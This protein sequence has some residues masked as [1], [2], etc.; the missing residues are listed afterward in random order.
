MNRATPESFKYDDEH[1]NE[2]EE[3]DELDELEGEEE[4]EETDEAICSSDKINT[5]N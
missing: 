1:A 5:S 2:Q 3:K 4:V